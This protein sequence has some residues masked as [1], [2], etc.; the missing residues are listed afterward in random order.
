MILN[1]LYNLYIFGYAISNVSFIY[2]SVYL[3][4]N[5]RYF[6]I[7][8][9]QVLTLDKYMNWHTYKI[10]NH[11]S[12][13]FNFGSPSS[14]SKSTSLYTKEIEEIPRKRWTISYMIE[15]SV[16]RPWVTEVVIYLFL[17]LK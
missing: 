8:N 7:K 9:I 1:V 10:P 14:Q 11:A 13:W 6:N 16:I 17:F 15:S 12:S 3:P 2:V 4:Y 5:I